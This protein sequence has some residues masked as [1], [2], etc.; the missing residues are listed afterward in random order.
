MNQPADDAMRRLVAAERERLEAI[1]D[2]VDLGLIRSRNLVGDLGEAIAARFYGVE[3]EPPS[4]PGYDLVSPD[5][6]RVQ[7]RAL[8]CTPDRTRRRIG[9]MKEPYDLLLAMRLNEDFSPREAI[10]VPRA[11]I[12]QHFDDRPVVWTASFA[13]DANRYISGKQLVIALSKQGLAR[14]A[15]KGTRNP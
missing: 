1:R 3:L 13:A 7:V 15:D 5:G 12:Q 6:Q 4:T 2:L 10:E 14:T 8:R 9:L 11:T